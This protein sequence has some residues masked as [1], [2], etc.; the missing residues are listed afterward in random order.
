[1]KNVG[2]VPVT[3]QAVEVGLANDRKLA[4]LSPPLA[5]DVP[6]VRIEPGEKKQC[7]IPLADLANG[8]KSEG[9]TGTA[10]VHAVARDAL[11][12]K[13]KRKFKINVVEWADDRR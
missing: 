7:H 1:M 9:Y 5:G 2:Q 8:L 11:D 13:H 10:K 4:M 3:L 12:T 6:P